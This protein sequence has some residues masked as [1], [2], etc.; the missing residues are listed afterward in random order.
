MT[1]SRKRSLGLK[2]CA[3]ITRKT[4]HAEKKRRH[5]PA[6]LKTPL[7]AVFLRLFYPENPANAGLLTIKTDR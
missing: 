1:P 5:G 7:L 4:E 2:D 6:F 3:S